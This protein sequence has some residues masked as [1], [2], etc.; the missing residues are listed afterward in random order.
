MT[1]S[2]FFF[3]QPLTFTFSS[4]SVNTWDSILFFILRPG[5]VEEEEE[6]TGEKEGLQKSHVSHGLWSRSLSKVPHIMR[7][8]I[9]S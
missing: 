1:A 9:K 2:C 3:L 5:G 7:H 6:K 4:I 8:M